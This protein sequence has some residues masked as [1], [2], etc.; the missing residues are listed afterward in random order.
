M[1]GIYMEPFDNIP[2]RTIECPFKVGDRIHEMRTQGGFSHGPEY[3][4][5]API[6][7]EFDSAKPDA[8]VTALT[9]RG[10]TYRYDHPIPIGRAAWGTTTEGGECF[11]GGFAYWRK[12]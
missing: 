1:S 8:T 4:V 6:Q 9:A 2:A 11:E 10:F 12:I 7:W 3:P 5:E